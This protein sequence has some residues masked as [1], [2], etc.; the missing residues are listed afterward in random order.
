MSEDNVTPI[1]IKLG[2]K[3][4]LKKKNNLIQTSKKHK[5]TLMWSGLFLILLIFWAGNLLYYNSMQLAKPVFP[6]HYM[7]T[8]IYN[9]TNFF[10]ITW[11][12]N[13]GPGKK[14]NEIEIEQLNKIGS[15]KKERDSYKYQTMYSTYFEITEQDKK[16]LKDPERELIV[17]NIKVYYDDGTS[18]LVNIGE[19]IF[20]ADDS[21]P[22]NVVIDMRQ[23]GASTD[24][25]GLYQVE[26]MQ[27]AAM[28]KVESSL[29]DKLD[30]LFELKLYGKSYDSLTYP[31]YE[32]KGNLLSF[33]YEYFQPD[34]LKDGFINMEAA[35]MIQFRKSDGT[36]VNQFISTNNN[37]YYS[38]KDIKTLVRNG[39]VTQ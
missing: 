25:T 16:I 21:A 34:I 30:H 24:G 2:R 7:T 26:M 19:L 38:E 36:K 20:R 18:E 11:L 33:K 28:E 12:E 39:G 1:I 6:A 23:S 35:V 15:G 10:E 22:N 29:P 8:T 32:K 27:N 3:Y 14:V 4:E 9:G 13:K 5:T 31:R 37:L 17:R